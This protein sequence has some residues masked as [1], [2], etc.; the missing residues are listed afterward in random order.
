MMT[1]IVE[2]RYLGY[3]QDKDSRIEKK[4]GAECV[5]AGLWFDR[6]QLKRN[7]TFEF[8]SLKKAYAAARKARMIHGVRAAVIR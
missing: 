6:H 3:D 5:G 7:V 2:A 1:Y 4:V 8:K